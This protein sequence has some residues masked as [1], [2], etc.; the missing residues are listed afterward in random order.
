MVTL[1]GRKI[2]AGGWL[3]HER[4][5]LRMV[6]DAL[7]FGEL[8]DHARRTDADLVQ[9][10]DGA[11]VEDEVVVETVGARVDEQLAGQLPLCEGAKDR[12]AARLF[13]PAAPAVALGGGEELR[14][15]VQRAVRRAAYQPFETGVGVRAKV[16]DRLE[17]RAQQAGLDD[18]VKAF[19]L[20]ARF[21]LRPYRR[22][23]DQ[24][25]GEGGGA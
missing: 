16:D 9:Q 23:V 25:E 4:L 2:Q 8:D 11:A 13:E 6:V 10:V 14:R 5:T 19:E 3:R 20:P 24:M 21:V 15:R 22:R 18:I 12:L 17:V 7:V 1:S